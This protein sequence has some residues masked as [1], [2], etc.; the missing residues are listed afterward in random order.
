M[1]S[2]EFDVFPATFSATQVY[3]PASRASAFSINSE[4]SGITLLDNSLPVINFSPWYHL[5]RGFGVPF[6]GHVSVTGSFSI[7]LAFV[8]MSSGKY[9]GS[10]N[11]FTID[12]I[13][14][15]S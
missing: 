14:H 11:I 3:R 5:I 15:L 2:T 7:A 12:I 4:P 6:A 1:K 9:G 13:Q 8:G 10:V